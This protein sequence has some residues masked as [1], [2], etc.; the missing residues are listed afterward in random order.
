MVAYRTRPVVTLALVAG[1]AV[2]SACVFVAF[3]A[4]GWPRTAWGWLISALLGLPLLVL[5]AVVFTLAFEVGRAGRYRYGW[6]DRVPPRERAV[7]T[8]AMLL[9]LL[10]AVAVYGAVLWMVWHFFLS[11]GPIRSQFR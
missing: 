10:A 3:L 8:T 5:A 4:P 6:W 1:A 2:L 7:R 11:A 9:R